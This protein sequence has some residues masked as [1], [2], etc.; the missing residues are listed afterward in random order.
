[1]NKHGGST[2]THETGSDDYKHL[3]G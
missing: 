1:M 3:A 2:M